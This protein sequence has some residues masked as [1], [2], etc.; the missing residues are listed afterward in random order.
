MASVIRMRTP[1]VAGSSAGEN[2]KGSVISPRSFRR[3][4]PG[5]VESPVI[6]SLGFATAAPPVQ[7]S[8]ASPLPS[9][10]PSA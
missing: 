2:G 3:S 9:P 8:Q 10:S 7:G 1:L 4:S 6:V 5:G